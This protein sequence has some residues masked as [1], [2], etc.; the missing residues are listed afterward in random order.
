MEGGTSLSRARSLLGR[1]ARRVRFAVA[2]GDVR[3]VHVQ[4]DGRAASTGD[5]GAV[6]ASDPGPA[7]QATLR[8]ASNRA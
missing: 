3:A 7:A 8:K 4:T 5:R 1:S 2:V 6:A